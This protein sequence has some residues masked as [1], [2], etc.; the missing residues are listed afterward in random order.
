M[1][2]FF[3][4]VLFIALSLTAANSDEPVYRAVGDKV[5][6]KPGPV[7]DPITIIT[8]KHRQNIA[9]EWFNG[10]V[11]SFR[12]FKERGDINGRTGALTITGLTP[13]DS[14]NYTAE[15]NHK[16]TRTTQLQVISRVSK[17]TV[18][19]QWDPDNSYW[20]LT[21]ESNTTNAEP[22]TYSWISQE[23]SWDS[24]KELRITNEELENQF[25]CEL[26][27]PVSTEDSETA[28]NPFSAWKWYQTLLIVCAVLIVAAV[29][30][31]YW[32][33]KGGKWYQ[34]LLIVCAALILPAVIFLCV[35]YWEIKGGKWYQI[36]LIFC[37]ALIVPAA[38]GFYFIYWK[39]RRGK[40]YQIGLMV[41]AVL[42][43]AAV[44]VLYVIYWEIR[45][46]KWYQIGLM[47]WAALIVPAGFGFY[48]IY[49][50][51][52]RGKWYQIGLMVWAA[53]IVPAVIFL[54]VIY[55]E[56][57]QEGRWYQIGLIGCSALIVPAAFGFYFIYR[58]IRRGSSC[59]YNKGDQGPGSDSSGGAEPRPENVSVNH[60]PTSTVETEVCGESNQEP[61]ADADPESSSQT[62]IRAS[63]D[64]VLTD[65]TS[66][67]EE[68][69]VVPSVPD[70][71]SQD[72]PV[73]EQA[74]DLTDET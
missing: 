36:G 60:A 6:L 43:V 13:G 23:K 20:V 64:Q 69:S 65:A 1:L 48:F 16:E 59:R 26:S 12:Q 34:I 5:E 57:R 29:I 39:K 22:A 11:E 61:T 32:K 63:P 73:Q 33:I 38:F 21:C 71:L 62:D 50:K 8:W 31:F 17:P 2:T 3:T 15:I 56:I 54:Y 4:N 41:W 72:P 68:T 51:K 24:I 27:N 67:A 30:G 9:M 55:W 53:L 74:A 66:E 45:G 42:I 18:S 52:R 19:I 7:S 40:W 44:I 10:S 14:G 70:S 58:E 49:W 47:V 46:G 35:I 25:Y 28:Q 37:S